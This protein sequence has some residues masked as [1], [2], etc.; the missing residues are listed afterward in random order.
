VRLHN[1][2]ADQNK[3]YYDKTSKERRLEVNDK[4]CFALLGNQAGVKF[5]SF[6]QGPF[7]V[8]KKL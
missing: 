6:W 7:I 4:V 2:K 5:R 3:A 8:V 1:H